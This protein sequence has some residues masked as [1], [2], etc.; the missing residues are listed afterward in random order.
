V[1]A[2]H[3]RRAA[4]TASEDLARDPRAPGVRHVHL[5]VDRECADTFLGSALFRTV[6][7]YPHFTD[8]ALR[9]FE[10]DET[11]TRRTQPDLAVVAPDAAL[12]V[13]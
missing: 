9:R 12:T 4:Q 7:S 2:S 1:P 5:F 13:R 6:G 11:A 8:L 10:V 3:V